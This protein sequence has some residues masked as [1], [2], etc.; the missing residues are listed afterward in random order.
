MR[1]MPSYTY[2]HSEPMGYGENIYSWS[3]PFRRP[4][5]SASARRAEEVCVWWCCAVLIFPVA[6]TPDAVGRMLAL[7]RKG[8]STLQGALR[9]ALAVAAVPRPHVIRPHHHRYAAMLMSPVP[10]AR[11]LHCCWP[12][13]PGPITAAPRRRKNLHAAQ[14]R[15]REPSIGG[16]GGGTASEAGRAGGAGEAGGGIS[17]NGQDPQQQQQQEPARR[18]TVLGQ[19]QGGVWTD[20][21]NQDRFDAAGEYRVYKE[22][23]EGKKTR[24]VSR[25]MYDGTNYQGFQLQS[26]GRPTVQVRSVTLLYSELCTTSSIYFCIYC[27][28][29]IYNRECSGAGCIVLR[30]TLKLAGRPLCRTSILYMYHASYVTADYGWSSTI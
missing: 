18:W 29:C 10:R 9:I 26:N 30:R 23:L 19:S 28:C 7:A 11:V 12:R 6:S 2:T 13:V 5:T 4:E 3:Y 25:V 15:P 22:L 14:D 20:T 27:C 1:N 8:C 16:G 17:Q 24:F 21:R